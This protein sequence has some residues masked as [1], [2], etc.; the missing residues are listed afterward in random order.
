MNP[1][2]LIDLRYS[3]KNNF[4][5]ED[6]YGELDS[7][8]LRKLP[9]EML[10]EA[11]DFLKNSHPNLRFLVYD[12][13][14]PRDIQQKLWDALDTIPE[15]ERGQFVANPDEG[16]IHNYGA[17]IDLTLAY[18]D[19][20]PLDMGTDYD[21]FGKLAFPVLE[22]S[23]FADGKLTKEQINNRGILRNVMTNAG[24]TTIDSEWWHFDAFS[25]EQTKNKFQIIESLDEYY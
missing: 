7:C 25:Y 19:G 16:S 12:G 14:R 23:L 15:S 10:M 21:H 18:N 22:D 1:S 8:Y 20:K 9:A 13:L 2:I 24:F 3:T 17:A 11:H 5:G 6:I 4:L